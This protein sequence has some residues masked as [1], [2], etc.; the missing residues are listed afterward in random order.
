MA[1]A[2]AFFRSFELKH[3]HHHR[4]KRTPSPTI[5]N[6]HPPPPPPYSTFSNEDHQLISPTITKI[7][8][9]DLIVHRV[10]NIDDKLPLNYFQQKY[11]QYLK[12]SL[13]LPRQYYNDLLNK[14]YYSS[15][16][17]RHAENKD[18]LIIDFYPPSSPPPSVCYRPSSS[19]STWEQC[20]RRLNTE[21]RLTID[22]LE[23][24]KECLKQTYSH[25]QPSIPNKKSGN[26]TFSLPPP[27]IIFDRIEQ[28]KIPPC[29]KF[30]KPKL[31]KPIQLDTFP[32]SSALTIME[33]D[34]DDDDNKIESVSN[35]IKKF[36]SLS[37]SV[38]NA[39]RV[40]FQPSVMTYEIPPKEEPMVP[41]Q[42][43]QIYS[44]KFISRIPTKIN[45]SNKQKSSTT[46]ATTTTKTRI[47]IKN[48]RISRPST[49]IQ[50]K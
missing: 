24:A 16:T 19:V 25:P 10:I 48:S 13:L 41:V 23:Q 26:V 4:D 11:K 38:P 45:S 2:R 46:T 31:I 30:S 21:Y 34:H 27:P 5:A 40:H 50:R 28:S 36:N 37:P 18:K 3:H 33:S 17:G 6:P 43:K 1:K 15:F 14:R 29:I 22:A 20:V 8:P 32:L 42:D 49:T 35:I 44:K 39:P 47:P 12:P 7:N 9:R